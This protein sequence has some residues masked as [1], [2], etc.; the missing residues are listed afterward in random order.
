[1]ATSGRF[2]AGLLMY[3]E[4]KNGVEVFLVHPG[5]PFWK[6]KNEG[7]WTIPKGEYDA[8]ESPLAAAQREFT[9]ETGF[10]TEPPFFELGSVRQKSGKMVMAWAFEGDCD[11]ASLHSNTCMIQWP[12]RSGKQME[13]A[14]IDRG[15][16]FT[17][18]EAHKHIREE[19]KVLL[20]RLSELLI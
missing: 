1:M 16:W 2:S 4:R 11:P 10:S 12:P 5:G 7:A 20:E 9:E 18:A 14:E 13:I 3:R 17:L 8:T 6:K 15:E 19:Q